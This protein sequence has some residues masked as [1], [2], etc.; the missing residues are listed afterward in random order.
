MHPYHPDHNLRA[1]CLR[2]Q[3]HRA[4]SKPCHACLAMVHRLEGCLQSTASRQPE[5]R[6]GVKQLQPH[7]VAAAC[8]AMWGHVG[9]C[10]SHSTTYWQPDRPCCGRWGDAA[11]FYGK[12]SDLAPAFSFAA[13]NRALALY[14][15]GEA[16]PPQSDQAVREMRCLA[17]VAVRVAV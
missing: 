9:L 2:P 5:G 1:A 17:R 16:D 10:S 7:S 14:Q 3:L 11:Q 6:C 15:L 4:C 8:R 13:A 12:A